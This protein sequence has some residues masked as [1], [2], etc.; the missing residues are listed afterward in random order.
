MECSRIPTQNPTINSWKVKI[1]TQ[2]KELFVP[3]FCVYLFAIENGEVQFSYK[4]ESTSAVKNTV[5]FLPPL[6]QAATIL[7]ETQT[8]VSIF[9]VEPWYFLVH[10]SALPA[11]KKVSLDFF[12]DEVSTKLIS[13][14]EKSKLEFIAEEKIQLIKK[15]W[16][17]KEKLMSTKQ[18][19]RYLKAWF[20]LTFSKLQKVSEFEAFIKQD[21]QFGTTKNTLIE[22][23]DYDNFHDYSHFSHT[24][25]SMTGMAPESYLE[26]EGSI[27]SLFW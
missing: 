7:F 15:I 12:T 16:E 26:N 22:A 18:L 20:G 14:L 3:E 24:F 6:S 4:N 5:V 13:Y 11:M 21:C 19:N 2:K 9:R 10:F 23:V 1:L 25:K 8:A 17:T 27:Q